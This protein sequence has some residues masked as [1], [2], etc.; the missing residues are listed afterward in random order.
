M[1]YN[2]PGNIRELENAIEYA[3]IMCERDTIELQ[4]LPISITGSTE[5]KGEFKKTCKL[6]ELEAEYILNLLKEHNNNC[7]EVAAVLE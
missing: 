7:I 4:H 3:F 5:N 6:K 2:F 1:T